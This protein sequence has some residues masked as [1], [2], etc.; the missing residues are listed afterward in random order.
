[1][2]F[3]YSY[4]PWPANK[5]VDFSFHY[6]ASDDKNHQQ[7]LFGASMCLLAPAQ[8][9]SQGRSELVEQR[10]RVKKKR[11]CN[12]IYSSCSTGPHIRKDFCR[13]LAQY[14]KVDCP[15][16]SLTNMPRIKRF[17]EKEKLDF[18]AGCKFSICFEKLSSPW[19]LSEKL[20]DGFSAGTVP[21]YWG[22]TEASQYFNPAAFV[23]CHDYKSFEEVVEKVAEI[24]SSPSLYEEYRNAPP[25]LPESRIYQIPQQKRAH[26]AAIVNE[27]LAR[28]SRKRN[29]LLEMFRLGFLLCSHLRLELGHIRWLRDGVRY[30]SSWGQYAIDLCRTYWTRW[31]KKITPKSRAQTRSGSR[32]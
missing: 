26:Y 15:A 9:G 11:F 5:F 24:D 32:P 27:A 2:V 10:R 17:S 19:Y 12:F 29:R 6:Q 22:C 13:L 23:N 18:M 21:I 14:K 28:R 31:R 30:C 20:I 7:F 4:E 8:V 25:I 3:S 1:M 16:E